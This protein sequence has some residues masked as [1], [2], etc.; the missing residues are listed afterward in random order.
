MKGTKLGKAIESLVCDHLRSKGLVIVDQNVK[1]GHYEIDIVAHQG[2]VLIFVEVKAR[3]S[4]FEMT[5]VAELISPAKERRLVIAAD[6]YAERSPVDFDSC[7]FD[8][9]FVDMSGEEY[10]ILHYEA[11]FVPT[12][13]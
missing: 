2:R 11:A 7:R 13:Y 12:V 8:Y 1:V 6:A 10:D 9:V 5:D 4:C 3:S